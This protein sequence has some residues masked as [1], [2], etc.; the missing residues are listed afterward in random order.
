V[1]PGISTPNLRA[2]LAD[3]QISDQSCTLVAVEGEEDGWEDERCTLANTVVESG[4]AVLELSDKMC[5]ARPQA[6][7]HTHGDSDL[8][9]H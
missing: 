1:I 6:G 9:A 2:M 5:L 7:M 4:S 3:G 8:C